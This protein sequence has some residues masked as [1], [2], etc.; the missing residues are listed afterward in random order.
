MKFTDILLT[1]TLA[2]SASSLVALA[3]D[4]RTDL[5]Y[6]VCGRGVDGPGGLKS[7]GAGDSQ[8]VHKDEE[9]EVRC[10]K[11]QEFNGGGW[12]GKCRNFD[13]RIKGRSKIGG[14][15]HY[16]SFWDAFRKCNDADGRLCTKEEVENSCVKGTGCS[17]DWKQVWTCTEEEGDCL[18]S[19][20]C[21]SG[22][23]HP[24]GYCTYDI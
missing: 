11:E 19:A 6:V 5:R 24:D 10:C 1:I 22:R 21:C 15:C 12:S 16:L 3:A 14:K 17:Y 7:C 23:C 13:E 4:S 8:K 18:E 9:H 20:E 2:A